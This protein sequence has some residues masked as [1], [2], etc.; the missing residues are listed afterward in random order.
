MHRVIEKTRTILNSKK[1]KE[2]LFVITLITALFCLLIVIT[3]Y[4]NKDVFLMD[5]NGSVTGIERGDVNRAS[6]YSFNLKMVNG[7]D[8]KEKNIKISK[9]ALKKQNEK[10]Q[11][12]EENSDIERDAEIQ[13]II[14]DIESA[15]NTRILL[16]GKLSDGTRLYWSLNKDGINSAVYVLIVYSVL[17]LLVIK[18]EMD[19]VNASE[20]EKK[21]NILKNLPRFT[22]QLMLMMNAGM[23]LSDSFERISASYTKIGREKMDWFQN[24]I[25]RINESNKDKRISTATLI[26]EFAGK[27]N[28]KELIRISTILLEN[29]KRGS[30][31][32]ENLERESRFLWDDRKIVARENGK[33][34]DTKMAYPM[35]LLLVVLIIITMA[36]ALLN[37]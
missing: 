16:P 3:D 1:V 21:K 9:K 7:K 33:M 31:I 30:S 35:G 28:V 11:I 14:S 24:E 20:E 36:P 8:V 32:V 17:I 4:Q 37:L 13:G 26:N 5:K 34:I 27:N 6:E 29:E 2:R 22:N 15:D 19:T 25:V 10:K 23:I 12:N 18:N